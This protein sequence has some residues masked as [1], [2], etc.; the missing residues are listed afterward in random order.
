MIAPLT[1]IICLCL[2]FISLSASQAQEITVLTLDQAIQ[3]TLENNP[4]I[5]FS[6]AGIDIER[7]GVKRAKSAYYPE[8]SSRLIVPFIGRE[9][10]FFL[11]QLIYDFG[12]TSNRVKSSKARLRSSKYDRDATREDLILDTQIAYYTVLANTHL[13][14]AREKRVIEYEKRLERSKGFLEAGR[15]PAIDVTK[16]EVDLG[17]SKL[18]AI[19]AINE[20]EI[21]KVNLMTVM[22]LEG[23]FTFELE[24]TPAYKKEIIDLDSVIDQA[25]QTRPEIKSLRAKE[26]AMKANLKI[27]KGE[28][29]PLIFGRT[30]Y[31]FEGEGAETPGF[32]A[33]VGLKFPIFVGFSRFAD[34]ES[35]R[36][37][38]KRVK[39]EMAQQK[40]A[41]VSEIKRLYLD[42]E[43]SEENI[44]VIEDTKRSALESLELANERYRLR[45]ASDVELAEAE[46]LYA[47]TN[48]TYMQSI[49]NYNI[50]AARLK[51]AIGENG[52]TQE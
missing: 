48:A 47:T 23:E 52:Y 30:A 7:A 39:A 46:S 27:T 4:G 40:A 38:I 34:M 51:R 42:L 18:E 37:S 28:F 21:A 8:I 31:R 17:N 10:G 6:D 45:R 20:L 32:I 44:K 36:G 24:D 5:D 2:L 12:R 50:A 43:F 26:E 1:R 25:L 19:S 3:T 29:Y 15:I 11:D 49:Y 9:S 33:G 35:A 16:T 41:I 13:A 14:R 22:G